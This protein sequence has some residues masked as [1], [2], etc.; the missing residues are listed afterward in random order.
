[1]SYLIHFFRILG[2]AAGAQ[3]NPLRAASVFSWQIESNPALICHTYI[4]F[5]PLAPPSLHDHIWKYYVYKIFLFFPLYI[6]YHI[7]PISNMTRASTLRQ[8]REVERA[9]N[10]PEQGGYFFSQNFLYIFF[11]PKT[12]FYKLDAFYS[13][14]NVLLENFK[15]NILCSILIVN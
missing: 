9:L 6:F 5:L 7:G 1:M 11:I 2:C 13:G 14:C 8:Q 15:F 12:D 3:L 10:P 4:C